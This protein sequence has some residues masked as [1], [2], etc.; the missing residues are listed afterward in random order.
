[1]FFLHTYINYYSELSLWQNASFVMNV[2]NQWLLWDPICEYCNECKK[3]STIMGPI[4]GIVMN[5]KTNHYYGILYVGI[6]MFV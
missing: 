4:C 6:V 1:M 5:G 3:P 2:K